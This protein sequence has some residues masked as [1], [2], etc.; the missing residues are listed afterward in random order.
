MRVAIVADRIGWE[1]RQ[2]MDAADRRGWTAF[3]VNDADLCAGARG[4]GIPSADVHL[5]RSRS[6]PRCLALSGLLSDRG[7]RVVNTPE[8]ISVCQDKL[9]TSRALHNSGIPVPEFRVVLTRQDLMTAIE[10]LGLPCV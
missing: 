8:A 7:D 1:E 6:Y 3:W 10:T 4:S 2:F 9:L 5:M